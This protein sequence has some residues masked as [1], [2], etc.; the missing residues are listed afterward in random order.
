METFLQKKVFNAW[1]R[2]ARLAIIK[3]ILAKF[4]L[5]FATSTN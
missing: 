5:R 1:L 3:N 4:T 2:L